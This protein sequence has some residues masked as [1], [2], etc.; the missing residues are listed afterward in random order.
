[1]ICGYSCFIFQFHCTTVS[2]IDISLFQ[3]PSDTSEFKINNVLSGERKAGRK[4]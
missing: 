4:S 1:M 2:W 3:E